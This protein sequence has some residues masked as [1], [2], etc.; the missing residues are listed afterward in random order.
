MHPLPIPSSEAT[1]SAGNPS[2]RYS[3]TALRLIS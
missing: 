1:N 3:F 2:S